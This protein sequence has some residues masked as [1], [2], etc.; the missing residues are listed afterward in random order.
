VAAGVFE[1]G[2]GGEG[3]AAGSVESGV[4]EEF[5]D[6]DAVDAGWSSGPAR[7]AASTPHPRP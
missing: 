5:G 4:A 2:V 6:D 7:S 3:V 1:V